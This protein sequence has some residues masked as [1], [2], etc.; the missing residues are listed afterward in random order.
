MPQHVTMP[1]VLRK[2]KT[3]LWFFFFSK[4][5]ACREP[6]KAKE[7]QSTTALVASLCPPTLH[8]VCFWAALETRMLG[9]EAVKEPGMEIITLRTD[10]LSK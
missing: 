1:Y 2:Y 9:K 3:P 5:R 7:T 8:C 4:F 10:M 6:G